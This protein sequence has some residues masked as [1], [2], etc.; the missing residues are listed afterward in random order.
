MDIRMN[1]RIKDEIGTDTA[2]LTTKLFLFFYFIQ[3]VLLQITLLI[4]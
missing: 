4:Q 3:N 2:N 1:I